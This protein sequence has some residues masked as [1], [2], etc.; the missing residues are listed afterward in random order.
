MLLDSFVVKI[1]S[2]FLFTFKLSILHDVTFFCWNCFVYLRVL[3][4]KTFNYYYATQLCEI[5]V[6]YRNMMHFWDQKQLKLPTVILEMELVIIV[7]GTEWT[8]FSGVKVF[9]LYCMKKKLSYI[10]NPPKIVLMVK[11]I[12]CD[13]THMV[14]VLDFV[15]RC[16]IW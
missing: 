14:G 9:N 8:L 13:V 10:E 6:L 11:N 7:I 3:S 1:S 4:K 5:T 12:F 16:Y 15:P 2:Y